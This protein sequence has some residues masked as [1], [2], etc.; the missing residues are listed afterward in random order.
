MSMTSSFTFCRS[1]PKLW[2]A[3]A[4]ERIDSSA[5]G[6]LDWLNR[7]PWSGPFASVG[8]SAA[9]RS[10]VHSPLNAAVVNCICSARPARYLMRRG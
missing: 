6:A 2:L 9:N 4:K 10:S 8:A 7:Q 5:H 3:D 1:P